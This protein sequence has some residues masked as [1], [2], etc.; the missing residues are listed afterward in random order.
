[1]FPDT[2]QGDVVDRDTLLAETNTPEAIA[3]REQSTAMFEMLDDENL[4]AQR[5][6][7]HLDRGYHVRARR[8]HDQVAG[9]P[10][11]DPEPVPCVYYIHGGGMASMSCFN[12]MYRTWGTSSRI[13]ASPS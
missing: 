13:R 8:Q 11:Q 10:P 2:R 12:G 9:D 6:A 7:R 5:G 4:G 3:M 1:M